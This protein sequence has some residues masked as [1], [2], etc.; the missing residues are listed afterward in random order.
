MV[1]KKITVASNDGNSNYVD[2]NGGD[3]TRNNILK[4]QQQQKKMTVITEMRP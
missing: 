2:Y 4:Q 3:E 1:I